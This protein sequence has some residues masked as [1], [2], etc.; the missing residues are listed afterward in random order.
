[1]SETAE[2][3]AV[4][5][6]VSR[7]DQDAF[8]WQSQQRCAVADQA[9]VFADEILPVEIEQRQGGQLIIDHDEHPRPDTS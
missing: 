2:N 4:E 3:V 1:M 7:Q 9:G 6:T 5:Y 8:S